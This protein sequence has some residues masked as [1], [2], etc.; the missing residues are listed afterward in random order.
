MGRLLLLRH[1]ESTWNASGRWQGWHD[2]P[3]SEAGEAQAAEAGRVLVSLGVTPDLVASSDLSRARRTA[4]IIADQVGY[5]GELVV[6]PGLREQDLGEWSGLTR[7]EIE[8]RWPGELAARSAGFLVPVPGGETGGHFVA[9]SL[10]ALR[11]IAAFGAGTAVVVAH[12]G[13]VISV[14]RSLGLVVPHWRHSNL[15]GWWLEAGPGV[16][17]PGGVE[18]AVQLRGTAPVDLLTPLRQDVTGLA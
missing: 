8:A 11:R 12:G 9:R 10:S 6:E 17:A 7:D 4:E 1:G 2:A 15:C 13:T 5:V 3:L 16:A 14:E 18:P